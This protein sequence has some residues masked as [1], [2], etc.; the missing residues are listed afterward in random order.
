MKSYQLR[1]V[2]TLQEKK[3]PFL[4][5]LHLMCRRTRPTVDREHEDKSGTSSLGFN[6]NNKSSL[7]CHLELG[8]TQI[9]KKLHPPPTPHIHTDG[10]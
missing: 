5:D 1:L 3:L 4:L 6:H 7:V 8:G 9:E 2:E 10:C